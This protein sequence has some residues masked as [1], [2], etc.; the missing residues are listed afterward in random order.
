MTLRHLME[1]DDLGA[2]EIIS[3]L[4]LSAASDRPPMMSGLSAGLVFEKPSTRT[5]NSMEVAVHQLG[6]HPVS[7][8]AAEVGLGSRETPADVARVLSRYHAV[9]AARVND[10]RTLEEMA[11]ASAV[12]VINLL[13]DQSHPMQALADLLTLREAWGS[14]EGRTLAWVGDGNNVARSLALALSSCGASFRIAAPRGYGLPPDV[15]GHAGTLGGAVEVCLSP[16]AAVDGADAVATDVWTSMG[17]ESQA[18]ERRAAFAGF[19]VDQE[20]MARA[21]PEAVFLHCLPVHRGEE[22]TAEVVDGPQSH[23]WRQAENRLHTS[24]GLLRFLLGERSAG[25]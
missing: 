6:G 24:R 13:C 10:R 7:M 1:I 15:V 11:E 23:A 20:L 8:Q 4:D 9:L 18:D 3:V 25:A 2:D 14:L 19:T 21:A 17:A 12:P 22:V 16:Q 5:R